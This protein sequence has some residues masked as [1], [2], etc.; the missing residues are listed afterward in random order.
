MPDGTIGN[1]IVTFD[2]DEG[3]T[4]AMLLE[5]EDYSTDHKAEQ[6]A[7]FL[8]APLEGGMEVDGEGEGEGDQ[9]EAVA[10]E[11][12]AEVEAASPIPM[13][14]TDAGRAELVE[15]VAA[16]EAAAEAMD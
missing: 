12:Q 16:E 13:E 9:G 10:T 8:L 7:W 5:S 2:M 11:A 14:E 4:T 15:R 3:T 6:G 1:F